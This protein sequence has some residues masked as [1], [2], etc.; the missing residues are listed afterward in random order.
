VINTA[1][2]D[3]L[4]R[5]YTIE[6]PEFQAEGEAV[7]RLHPYDQLLERRR[8]WKIQKSLQPSSETIE[9]NVMFRLLY[10]QELRR[11]LAGNGFEMLEFVDNLGAGE[12]TDASLFVVSRYVG[13]S[14]DRHANQ[15]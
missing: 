12:L 4:P 8:T 9:D 5:R 11:Y 13:K 1:A 2:T 7:Y 10:T 15:S 6:T 14:G 3:A